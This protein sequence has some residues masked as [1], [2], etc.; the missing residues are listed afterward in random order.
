MLASHHDWNTLLFTVPHDAAVQLRRW[1]QAVNLRLIAGQLAIKGEADVLLRGDPHGFSVI[2]ELPAPGEADPMIGTCG[3]IYTY[4]FIPHSDGCDLQIVAAPVA[5]QWVAIEPTEPLQLWLPGDVVTMLRS[6]PPHGL[7]WSS[8]R[9]TADGDDFVHEVSADELEFP[10]DGQMYE[11]LVA[12]GWD[13]LQI[14]AY[15][16]RFIPLSVG[17]EMAVKHLPSERE[18][19]LT[20]GVGW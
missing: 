1:Q 9:L 4:R 15:A 8:P 5:F 14:E 2:T 3:G 6:V 18:I 13:P 10:I 12:W 19:H 16:Y 20:E 11:R 7:E 17:C